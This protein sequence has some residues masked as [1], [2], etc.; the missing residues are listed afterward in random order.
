MG[1]SRRVYL[2]LFAVLAELVAIAATG[3]QGV[4]NF[5]ADHMA[6]SPLGDLFL[7][8]LPTLAWGITPTDARGATTILVAQSAAIGTLLVLTFV[9]M[10]VVVRGS[11]TFSGPFF[12]AIPIV[13]VS[14]LGAKFVASIVEYNQVGRLEH[15]GLGRFGYAL[16]HSSDNTSVMFSLM[17]GI[18]VALVVGIVG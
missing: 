5:V 14:A 4:T 11:S 17:C 12:S 6:T 9:L 13:V 8:S 7:R 3:N 15:T 18:W 16:F 1:M 10:L 2:A